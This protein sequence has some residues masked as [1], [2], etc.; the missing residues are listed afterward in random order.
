MSL[1]GANKVITKKKNSVSKFG[2]Y[3]QYLAI[4][5]IKRWNPIS[6]P[7]SYQKKKPTKIWN[8]KCRYLGINKKTGSIC[9]MTQAHLVLIAVSVAVSKL[10]CTQTVSVRHIKLSSERVHVIKWS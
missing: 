3:F 7:I 1:R 6:Y 8:P 4:S 5:H 9:D 10:S 2:Q